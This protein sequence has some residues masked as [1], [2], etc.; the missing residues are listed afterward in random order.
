MAPR[1]FLD[2]DFIIP[3]GVTGLSIVGFGL[4][5]F[6]FQ[7]QESQ[8]ELPPEATDTPFKYLFLGTVTSTPTFNLTEQATGNETPAPE[9]KVS[10]SPSSI[11]TEARTNQPGSELTITASLAFIGT[12]TLNPAIFPAGKFDDIDDRIIYDGDWVSEIVD[13]AYGETLFISTVV[14]DTAGFTFT[15]TQFTIGYLEDPGLGIVTLI[16]DGTEYTLDQS[17]GFEW[18]SPALPPG[19]HT[20]SMIHETGEIIILDYLIIV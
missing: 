6:I 17:S 19:E 9:R 13:T 12:P 8:A 16:I 1:K 20:V 2:R 18:V 5:F 11:T 3:I 7:I 10:S 4:V 15:G 14:G